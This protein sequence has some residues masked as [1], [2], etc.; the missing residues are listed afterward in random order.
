MNQDRMFVRVVWLFVFL[1]CL[2]FARVVADFSLWRVVTYLGGYLA[3]A[4]VAVVA[5]MMEE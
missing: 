4:A 3:L 5:F 2:G 1:C